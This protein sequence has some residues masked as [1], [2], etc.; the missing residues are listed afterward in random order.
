MIRLNFPLVRAVSF[1]HDSETGLFE[2]EYLSTEGVD[3]DFY[4]VID[5][6]G[7]YS[8]WKGN[9]LCDIFEPEEYTRRKTRPNLDPRGFDED[10]GEMEPYCNYLIDVWAGFF[11][12]DDQPVYYR[13]VLVSQYK[14][15]GRQFPKDD[16]DGVSFVVTEGKIGP[17]FIGVVDGYNWDPM[18]ADM[19]P[20]CLKKTGAIYDLSGITVSKINSTVPSWLQ[21]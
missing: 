3:G 18:R 5:F 17:Q 15:L 1:F 6:P 4:N 7:C 2:R 12:M 19:N 21:I 14:E 9:R 8:N 20:S 16:I 10:T 11:D 13:D